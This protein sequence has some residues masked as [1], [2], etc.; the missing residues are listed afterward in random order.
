MWLR[1]QLCVHQV[2]ECGRNGDLNRHSF[3]IYIYKNKNKWPM[4]LFLS[5][6]LRKSF[7]S[8]KKNSILSRFFFDS[9]SLEKNRAKI[10]RENRGQRNTRKWKMTQEGWA[11]IRFRVAPSLSFPPQGPLQPHRSMKNYSGMLRKKKLRKNSMPR[12][13]ELEVGKFEWDFLRA[14]FLW[15]FFLPPIYLF[16][17]PSP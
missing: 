13:R 6:N 9:F 14:L 1:G 10:E 5:V 16:V 2:I 4:V 15:S 8:Q 11:I 7:R 17:F 3:H 12:A